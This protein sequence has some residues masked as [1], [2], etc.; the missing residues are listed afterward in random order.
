MKCYDW[1]FMSKANSRNQNTQNLVRY[2]M[3]GFENQVL[4]R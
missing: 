3:C 1:K 2:D 4:D